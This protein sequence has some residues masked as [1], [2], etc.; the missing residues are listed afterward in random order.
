MKKP[1][2][3]FK[4]QLVKEL[5]TLHDNLYFVHSQYKAFKMAREKASSN[6]NVAIV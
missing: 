1:Y 2:Q 3:K 6:P 4:K 5:Y